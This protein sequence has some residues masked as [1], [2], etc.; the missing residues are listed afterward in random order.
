MSDVHAHD[1]RSI[2]GRDDV[3]PL[4]QGTTTLGQT[5][6]TGLEVELA[7]F[8]ARTMVPMTVAQNGVLKTTA[9]ALLG[10]DFIR[11]EPTA[12]MLEVGSIAETPDHLRRILDDSNSKITILTREAAKI[13]LKR[14]YF[15]HLPDQT[16]SQLLQHLIAIPRYQAFFGPP[17]ADMI[18]IAA[19]FSVCKSNQVSVSY[20]DTD[21]LLNNIR[22][23]YALAPFLFLLT[24]NNP[25]FNEGQPFTGHAGMHHRSALKERG[26][27]PPY[28]YTAQTGEAYI[29]DH[30][31]H[32]M[33]NPLFVYYNEAG[34]LVRLPSGTW[35]S[36]N[37][38]RAKGLNTATNYFFAQSILW[39]DV[40]IAALKDTDDHVTGHRFEARMFGVGLHQHQTALL[41]VAALA[42]DPA[43][44]EAVRVLL[45]TIGFDLSAPETLKTPLEAAYHSARHHNGQFLDIPYGSGQMRDFARS[46]GTLLSAASLLKDFQTECAPLLEI[47]ET[48]NT[49]SKINALSCDTL[50]KANTFQKLID[51]VVLENPNQN[52]ANLFAK[53]LGK[54][55]RTPLHCAS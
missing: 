6:K 26:G 46:F 14:A 11:N 43:F 15:Q 49:D 28:V 25:P 17:R 38:L 44:Y 5:S 39:P 42:Y 16:A 31:A 37:A 13:G 33:D 35:T 29:R 30:I 34:D 23:L 41:I 20:T 51:P 36:F 8:D 4:Y 54:S 27:V 19:Y 40:K 18:D 12:D 45:K 47:C 22:I 7:F 21:H 9:N 10:G 24:D 32:V 1:L 52:S 50:D 53:T 55:T 3:W 2:N 48:G